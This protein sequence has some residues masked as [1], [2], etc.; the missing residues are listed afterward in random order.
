[1]KAKI[2]DRL[3]QFIDLKNISLNAFD[4]SIGASNGYIGRQLKNNAS[5]GG[6][7]IEEIS[8]VYQDLNIEW[9]ITGKGKMLKQAADN[10][11]TEP[12]ANIS[13]LLDRI[14]RLSAEKARLE[15]RVAE[16]ERQKKIEKPSPYTIAAEPHKELKNR[17]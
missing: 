3:K 14:E 12:L 7:I 8:C 10:Q 1:M 16:L 11:T 13:E 9:L 6:D 2:I 4:K 17:K 5:I 15:D